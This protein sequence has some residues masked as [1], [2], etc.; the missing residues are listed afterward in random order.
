MSEQPRSYKVWEPLLLSIAAIIGMFAG[1]KM[2]GHDFGIGIQKLEPNSGA[3]RVTEIIR[4][5]EEKYVDE[6]GSKA[7]VDQ[8]IKGILDELDPHSGYISP[9]ELA[10]INE[11]MEGSFEGIGVMF[12]VLKD[13]IVILFVN[14][15]GPAEKAGMLAH[16]KLILADTLEMTGLDWEM[17]D[18]INYLR[19][20]KGSQVDLYV[21]RHGIDSLIKLEVV[22]DKIPIPSV[23]TAYML[24]DR[25]GYIKLNSFSATTYKEFMQELEVM[26]EEDSLENLV[27]DL[28]DNP[29]GYL[30]EAVNIL[31]QLFEER[32]RLLVYTEGEN[33][34]RMEYKSTGKPFYPVG[35]IAVLINE[36]SA[37]ASEIIAGAIQ[38]HDRGVIIGEKS[39]GKGLVQEQYLLEDG[40]ALRL[41]TARY[42]TPS[43]RS[44]QKPYTNGYH[45][46]EPD[47]SDTGAQSSYHTDGGREVFAEGGITPDIHI[48]SRFEWPVDGEVFFDYNRLIEFMF[49][50][51]QDG[52]TDSL[53]TLEAY[54]GSFPSSDEVMEQAM[55]YFEVE[56]G[57]ETYQSIAQDWDRAFTLIQAMGA[58]YRVGE[59]AWF[60]VINAEDPLIQKAIEVVRDDTRTTL[61][62]N[63][64]GGHDRMK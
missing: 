17:Q 47:S 33:V 50:K 15:G 20:P 26:V 43:G 64:E 32:G 57:T 7:L 6:I 44:I 38:D 23:S 12:H 56:E 34:K 3:S 35:N 14:E 22:R 1:A 25:T 24:D 61:K 39:Y 40:G 52:Y 60:K 28:R 49:Y 46:T 54:L 53:A 29:G 11:R 55:E 27:I 13:T 2:S 4:F 8:A 42:Y 18:Y 36:G 51:F 63:L 30:K 5:I 9:E 62:L 45:D 21:R 10:K 37:S 19:G 48:E 16:D 41:T 59:E 31:S 58:S